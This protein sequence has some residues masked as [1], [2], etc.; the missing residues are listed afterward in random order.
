MKKFHNYFVHNINLINYYF[1]NNF[2]VSKKISLKNGGTIL[3]NHNSYF[4]QF[5]Y[6][7]LDSNI[8]EEGIDFYFTNGYIKLKLPPA[9][10]RNQLF[11][12]N[13]I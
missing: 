13:Y 7:Y 9:F 4:G 8:W 12:I 11:Q 10:L 2:K 3:F 6:A 1:E 5:D